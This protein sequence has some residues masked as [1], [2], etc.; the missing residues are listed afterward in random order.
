MRRTIC[1]A[2]LAVSVTAVSSALGAF[3]NLGAGTSTGISTDGSVV[4]FNNSGAYIWTPTNGAKPIGAAYLT[5]GVAIGGSSI[6]HATWQPVFN[7]ADKVIVGGNSGGNVSAWVGDTTGAGN[8][9][10]IG[11]GT[12]NCTSAAANNFWIGGSSGTSPSI[13]AYR[14]KASSVSWSSLGLPS[15]YN[16]NAYIYGISDVGSYAGRAQYG[17]SGT[18]GARAAIGGGTLVGLRP[19]IGPQTTNNEGAANAI[20]RNG[21]VAGGWSTA[22]A[23]ITRQGTIWT[24]SSPNSPVAVP[25]LGTD[26]YAEVQALN[27]DGTIAAGYARDLVNATRRIWIWD[28][29]NGTQDLSAIIPDLATGWTNLSVRGMSGD[30]LAI[31]GDGTYGGVTTAWVAVIPEPATIALV[32]LGLPLLRR[33]R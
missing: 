20:S 18:G 23:T 26:N 29:V 31:T 25:L 33:R 13:N 16:P 30:G 10:S 14:Y 2:A 27:S 24:I 22:S 4:S 32:L 15:G 21:S 9:Y 17:G 28:A 6:T 19:L 12:A 3:Y 5:A 1:M 11:S 8:W 7:G